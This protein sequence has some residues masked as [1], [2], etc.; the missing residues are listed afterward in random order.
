MFGGPQTWWCLVFYTFYTDGFLACFVEGVYRHSGGW[1]EWPGHRSWD[2]EGKD[3]LPCRF[4]V[5]HV[6]KKCRNHY[7]LM[8]PCL[9]DSCNFLNTFRC[10][11]FLLYLDFLSIFICQ[12]YGKM[13]QTVK[14]VDVVR[15]FS[16]AQNRLTSGCFCFV[17]WRSCLQ[18]FCRSVAPTNSSWVGWWKEKS[19]IGR[20][21]GEQQRWFARGTTP[22][23]MGWLWDR[24]GL[25]GIY[26]SSHERYPKNWMLDVSQI[27][28]KTKDRL[29]SVVPRS[30]ILTHS[31]MSWSY[32][33]VLFNTDTLGDWKGGLFSRAV[34]GHDFF[35]RCWV[36]VS[37]EDF[38]EDVVAAFP[39]LR[40]YSVVRV[41]EVRC[42]DTQ[43][44]E[45]FL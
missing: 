14:H 20:G 34:F 36:V 8:F 3:S 23:R 43:K 17:H 44:S 40:L 6:G 38:Y 21:H 10:P 37:P 9:L 39:E 26:G 45:F 27:H 19:P 25:Y 31:Q 22:R 42:F 24:L 2:T 18:G 32:W 30:L 35:L 16:D 11:F 33:I 4:N 5:D 41:S 1:P 12:I 28:V 7:L 29:R 13:P 15:L